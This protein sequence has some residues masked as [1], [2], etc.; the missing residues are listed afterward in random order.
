MRHLTGMIASLFVAGA[1]LADAPSMTGSY[2]GIVAC[3]RTE[4]GL[5]GVFQLRLDIRVIQQ[6]DR[7]DIATWTA[8]DEEL[9]RRTASLYTGKVAEADGRISGYATA[10]RPDFDYQETIRILPALIDD[11]ALGFSADT[12]FITEDLPGRQGRLI[13]ESCRWVMVRQSTEMPEM[14]RCPQ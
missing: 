9:K 10:C 14:E 2:S 6:G 12:I 13:V 8:E 11:P 5:P 1:A 3:D 4:E 7:I